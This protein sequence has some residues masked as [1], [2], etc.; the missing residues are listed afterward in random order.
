MVIDADRIIVLDRGRFVGQGIH[1]ELI[2]E[3]GWY[4]NASEKQ[5][6][7]VLHPSK[8]STAN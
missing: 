1:D 7:S 6:R 5:V 8:L 4:A 3:R 2:E